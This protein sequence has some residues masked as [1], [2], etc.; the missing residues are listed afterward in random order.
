MAHADLPA[1]GSPS[2]TVRLPAPTAWP[3]VL[4]FGVTLLFAGLVTSASVSLLGAILVIS[5]C[6]GWFCDI[7][8]H[9][10]HV[11]VPIVEEY[12]P[13]TTARSQVA[14]L[15]IAPDLPESFA[16]ARNLSRLC[17]Y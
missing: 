12:A 9:E 17:W 16:P 4:A 1:E 6:V 10:K 2:G 5:G 8:P 3:I 11:E 13:I 15:P 7:L 14:R